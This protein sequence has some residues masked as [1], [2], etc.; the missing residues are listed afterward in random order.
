[1]THD[2]PLPQ[3]CIAGDSKPWVPSGDHEEHRAAVHAAVRAYVDSQY[4]RAR[5]ASAV[6]AAPDGSLS[7]VISGS[8]T[9]LR[10]FWS[11]SWRSVWS[12][13]VPSGGA[14]V[15]LTGDV[16]IVVHYFEDGNVQLHQKK[17]VS[18]PVA[19]A[20]ATPAA[21]ATAVAAALS[22]AEKKLQ[23]ALEEMYSN[24]SEES[25]KDMRR[26]LPVSKVKFEWTGAQGRLKHNL[27]AGPK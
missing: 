1:M 4:D 3:K 14:S 27:A 22:A 2:P 7:I 26:I 9:N 20:A 16:K 10:N 21:F 17:A 23:D 6:F 15:Q 5:A 19:A 25:F 11:G 12:V 8:A 18:T 13:P 24:M